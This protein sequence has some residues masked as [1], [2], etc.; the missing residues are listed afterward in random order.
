MLGLGTWDIVLLAVAAFIAVT[1][2]VTLMQSHRDSLLKKLRSD[3]NNEQQRLQ[4][5]ER[6]KKKEEAKKAA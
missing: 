2:L 6:T 3:F 5:E 1:T 4:I